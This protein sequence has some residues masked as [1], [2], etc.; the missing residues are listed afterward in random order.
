MPYLW[1]LGQLIIKMLKK[2]ALLLVGKFGKF[3]LC[4]DSLVTSLTA[5]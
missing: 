5:T 3:K 1:N 4:S 2:R